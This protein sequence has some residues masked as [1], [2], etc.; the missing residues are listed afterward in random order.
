MYSLNFYIFVEFLFFCVIVW[1][2][3]PFSNDFFSD[4]IQVCEVC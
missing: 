1:N 3:V 2:F 4:L